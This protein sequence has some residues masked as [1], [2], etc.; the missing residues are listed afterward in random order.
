M[1]RGAKVTFEHKIIV[2]LDDIRAVTF[3]CLKCKSRTTI[4]PDLLE[5]VPYACGSCNAAWRVQPF[6]TDVTTTGP[7][8]L[9]LIQA[10]RTMRVLIRENKDSFRILL[11]F[12]EPH[13][14]KGEKS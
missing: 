1:V 14:V 3:E 5:T 9:A 6:V 10:I 7:A 11:E 13:P 4:L 8:A 2:G 12:A